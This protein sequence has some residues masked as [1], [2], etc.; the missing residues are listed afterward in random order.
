MSLLV[1][2]AFEFRSQL[3]VL[4]I[5]ILLEVFLTK[6]VSFVYILK[7]STFCAVLGFALYNVDFV[8]EKFLSMKERNEQQNFDNDDYVR[9]DTYA[10]YNNIFLRNT[11]EHIF[12]RGLAGIDGTYTKYVSSIKEQGYIWADWGLIGLTWLLGIPAVLCMLWYSIIPIFKI[13]RKD[14]IYISVWFLF[15]F[16]SSTFNREFFRQGIFVIQAFALFYL[17]RMNL[18]TRTRQNMKRFKI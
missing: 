14:C 17:D 8:H 12:G 13:R 5:F 15:L 11:Y 16:F 3:A 1:A 18:E 10:Y 9:L 4:P 6:K 2:I 7:I